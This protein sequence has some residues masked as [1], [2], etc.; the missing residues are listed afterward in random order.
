MADKKT[1]TCVLCNKSKAPYQFIK[2]GNENMS[3]NFG[4]CKE[5]IKNSVNEINTHLAIIQ[6]NIDLLKMK[7]PNNKYITNIE[8]G[9]KIIQKI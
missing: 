9:S 4:Y 3:D 1:V 6:T 7:I 5:C 2:Y 8:S